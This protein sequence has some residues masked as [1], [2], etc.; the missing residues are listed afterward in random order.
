MSYTVS[1]CLPRHPAHSRFCN[2]SNEWLLTQK[3]SRQLNG[4]PRM[5]D[6][7][8]CGT[9]VMTFGANQCVFFFLCFYFACFFYGFIMTCSLP[10]SS[11]H[12]ISQAR[13]LEW[14]ALSFSR[15]GLL[16]PSPGDVPHPGT[17]PTSSEVQADS[18]LLR[19][20]GS[21]LF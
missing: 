3:Q 19:H 12:G 18:L 13:T 20:Q 5:P 7:L 16:F 2:R 14:V 6:K 1:L 21:S 4:N 10:G 11:A 9:W 17:E 15:S 8:P